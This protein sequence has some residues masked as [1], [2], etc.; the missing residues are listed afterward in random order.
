MKQIVGILFLF[1]LLPFGMARSQIVSNGNSSEDSIA[2]SIFLTDSLGNPSFT[3][4]D[5][6]YVSVMGPSGDSI[7]AY[8]GEAATTGLHIDSTYSGL[9]GWNYIYTE[10]IAVIDGGG[11]PGVYELRF[12]AKDTNPVYVN[13]VTRPFQLVTNPFADQLA[14]ISE[15]LDSMIVALDTLNNRPVTTIA[16]VTVDSIHN[17]RPDVN[18]ASLSGDIQA[19]D[20][21]ETMLDGTGGEILALGGLSIEGARGD[22]GVFRV[23]NSTGTAVYFESTG[24]N[25]SGLHAIGTGNGEGIKAVG[26]MLG[27]GNGI[28]ATGGIGGADFSGDVTG[29]LYGQMYGD[30][31]GVATP[32]DT[33]SSGVLI[34]RTGD[35]LAFQGEA[36]GL[37]KAQIAD[38]LIKAGMVRYNQPDSILYLR[39]LHVVGTQPGD[40]A[41]IAVGNG[42]GHGGYFGSSGTGHGGFFR[43]GL[44][45]GHGLIGWTTDGH[46]MA[47]YGS[48][49][50]AGLYCEATDSGAGAYFLGGDAVNGSDSGPGMRIRGRVDD[51]LYVSAGSQNNKHGIQIDGGTGAGGDGVRI[52]GNGTGG[53]GISISSADGESIDFGTRDELARSMWGYTIDTAWA[54][55]SFGDSAKSWSAPSP[56]GSG[57][58]PVSVSVLDSTSLQPV[59]QARLTVLNTAGNV[60]LAGGLSDENGRRTFNLDAGTYRVTGFSPGYVLGAIDTLPV[61]GATS[62]TLYGYRF[63]PGQP[64]SPEL[65]RVYGFLY[66]IDGQPVE[67]AIVTFALQSGAQLNS[68]II[69][70]YKKSASTDST[71]YFYLDI[72]PSAALQAGD[73]YTVTAGNTAGMILRKEITVP[74]LPTW[75]LT[76]E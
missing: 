58:Y 21:L 11:R 50:K 6:F 56:F 2:V 65:C 53:D 24:G 17:R 72:I 74:D 3:S 73:V 7:V 34:A 19:A 68:M 51:G 31:H 29:S 45:S 76:W 62:D 42:S 35:S 23:T 47:L 4:A 28:Q 44:T 22:S 12:C 13:C 26:G 59:P 14:G 15:L 33:N 48:K 64:A 27:G 10:R 1:L 8:E 52:L 55:G 36:S 66:G 67:G 38:T 37:S 75:Q 32:T 70:P 49:E 71:G 57:I 69:S 43:G 30:V 16:A 18:T 40:T 63:D 9:T 54:S 46:G 5:S 39:G 41:L 20:N 61:G 60:V 25:G